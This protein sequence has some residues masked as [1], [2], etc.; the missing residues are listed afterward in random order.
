M[1]QSHKVRNMLT[2]TLYSR[3]GCCLCEEMEAIVRALQ[4][5]IPFQIKKVDISTDPKLNTRF[6]LEIPVLYIN[7]HFAFM[8]ELSEAELRQR[9]TRERKDA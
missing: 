5:E 7:G 8:Y 2:V 4:N 1:R 3:P 6:S 9:L